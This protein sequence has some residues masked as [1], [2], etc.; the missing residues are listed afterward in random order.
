MDFEFVSENELIETSPQPLTREEIYF[1]ETTNRLKTI[2]KKI[3][4]VLKDLCVITSK[5]ANIYTVLQNTN[6]TLLREKKSD[7]I[8]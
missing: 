1:I 2:E 6:C 4:E 8:I 5:I 3:E 7:A